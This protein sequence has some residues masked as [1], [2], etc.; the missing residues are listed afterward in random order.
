MAPS[1][2]TSPIYEPGLTARESTTTP[3]PVVAA[4][5][6]AWALWSGTAILL[7]LLVRPAVTWLKQELFRVRWD[8]PFDSWSTHSLTDPLPYSSDRQR[9]YVMP[10]ED[11]VTLFQRLSDGGDPDAVLLELWS[12]ATS[13][14]L[15]EIEEGFT[16]GEMIEAVPD[17]EPEA[18]HAIVFVFS[19]DEEAS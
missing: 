12:A 13:F 17:I 1:T 7:G 3:W 8:A 19:E 4:S 5:L 11:L 10:E 6:G 9:I 16:I 2:P 14:D 15:D 18:L